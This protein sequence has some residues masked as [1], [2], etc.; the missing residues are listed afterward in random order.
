MKN[1]DHCRRCAGSPTA[2]KNAQQKAD[3]VVAREEV[4]KTLGTLGTA[5]TEHNLVEGLLEEIYWSKTHVNFLRQ[6]VQEIEPNALVWGVVEVSDTSGENSSFTTK[7]KAGL[8]Q[9][10]HLYNNERKVYGELCRNALAIGIEQRKIDAVN[11]Y[12]DLLD[13]A[14]RRI[15]DSLREGLVVQGFE[16]EDVIEVW[17]ELVGEVVPRELLSLKSEERVD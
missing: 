3:A 7:E 2:R 10:L 4:R 9:W 14:L 6:Q 11:R 15:L 13:S 17:G 16:E 8:N 5:P 1:Q 12:S